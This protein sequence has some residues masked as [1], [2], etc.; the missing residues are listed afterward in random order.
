MAGEHAMPSRL[1]IRPDRPW[2]LI[3]HG[4]E[5]NLCE[6]A[7]L[8]PLLG[9]SCEFYLPIPP[10]QKGHGGMIQWTVMLCHAPWN[11]QVVTEG[12]LTLRV[13]LARPSMRTR[14]VESARHE[15]ADTSF[16][17]SVQ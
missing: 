13:S 10:F 17:I 15:G 14:H 1:R 11:C 7:F 16:R 12:I 5:I 2:R 4:P 3:E 6:S 8:E 9:M